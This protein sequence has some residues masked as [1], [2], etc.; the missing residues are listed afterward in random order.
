M[1]NMSS[2]SHE[3]AKELG[4]AF[5]IAADGHK[6][7]MFSPF[8][9]DHWHHMLSE[10]AVYTEFCNSTSGHYIHHVEGQQSGLVTFIAEYERRYGELSPH[11]FRDA[12]GEM[13]HVVYRKYKEDRIIYASWNCTPA[14]IRPFDAPIGQ[15]VEM[16]M[17]D[18]NLREDGKG[19]RTKDLK[20]EDSKK[21]PIDPK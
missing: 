18:S 12:E 10:P 20:I 13:D 21:S 9:D 17:K 14:K 11:W 1:S 16:P 19:S 4:R 8:L 3:A 15:N 6:V 7:E 2:M 5:A